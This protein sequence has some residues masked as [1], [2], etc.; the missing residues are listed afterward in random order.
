MLPFSIT[1]G[2]QTRPALITT[3][4][5]VDDG[6]FDGIG[7]ASSAVADP[8]YLA[9]SSS[10]IDALTLMVDGICLGQVGF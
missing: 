4:A 6:I 3:Q 7:V 1:V 9:E 10:L 2:W 8:I 5:A